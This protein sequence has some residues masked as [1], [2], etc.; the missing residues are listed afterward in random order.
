MRENPL[1]IGINSLPDGYD[2]DYLFFSKPLRYQYALEKDCE[3]CRKITKILTSNVKTSGDADEMIVNYNLLVKLGWTY[4]DDSMIMFLR[5]LEKTGAKEIYLAGFDGFPPDENF[6]YADPF[7]QGN[8][9]REKRMSLNEDI[10]S[11]LNDI[12]EETDGKLF[13]EFLTPSIYSEKVR[14]FSDLSD[15]GRRE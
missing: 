5:L 3:K 15:F 12:L 7:L 10:A 13:I 8:L 4:F 6:A 1:V 9:S 2:C 14:S 11:M